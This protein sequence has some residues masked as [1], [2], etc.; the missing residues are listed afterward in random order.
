VLFLSLPLDGG[1]QRRGCKIG[2]DIKQVARK[3][4]KNVTIE[5]RSLWRHL[6]RRQVDGIKFRR[7]HPIGNYVVDFVCLEKK[8]IIEID[9]GQHAINSEKEEARSKYLQNQ[10]YRIKDFG[11]T[12]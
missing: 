7:Q 5:E 12:M 9:G 3:L 8:L 10:G 11:T 2:Q 6:S 1:G 4:R